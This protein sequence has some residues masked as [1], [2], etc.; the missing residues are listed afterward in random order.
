VGT[1]D[2]VEHGRC[3]GWIVWLHLSVVVLVGLGCCCHNFTEEL[4]GL[5]RKAEGL[6]DRDKSNMTETVTVYSTSF[7]L[8]YCSKGCMPQSCFSSL[9]LYTLS[10]RY[11]L[12]T[13]GTY[14]K[15]L[16]CVVHITPERLVSSKNYISH[17]FRSCRPSD[18]DYKSSRTVVRPRTRMVGTYGY[19]IL[20][21]L[22]RTVHF[23]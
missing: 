3:G 5:M 2:Q 14:G 13:V 4:T 15:L 10:Y 12:Y 20:G 17:F 21:S 16:Q 22:L 6:L 1:D 11:V 9:I 8:G 18:Y 7:R 19:D 23:K